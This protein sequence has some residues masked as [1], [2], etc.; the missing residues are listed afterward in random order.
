MAARDLPAF[1]PKALTFLRALVRN[2]D[3][4]WFK[5]HKEDYDRFVRDPMIAVIERLDHDFRDF[6]PELVATASQSLFRIYRDTRFSADKAPLKTHVAAVFPHRDLGKLS[7]AALYL[8]LDAKQ[9]LLAGGLHGPT[10]KDLHAVRA[11][12]AANVSRFKSIV[13]APSFRRTTG[14]LQGERAARTPRGFAV[15]DEVAEYLK[16]KQF[17]VWVEMPAALATTSGFYPTVLKIFRA[18]A[19]LVRFVNEPLVRRPVDPLR[20]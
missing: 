16:F 10:A 6:A 13:E 2:N 19:P 18:A 1:A 15:P 9:V 20:P 3:R 12:I 5:A 4:E 14:G 7:G 17:L 8:Q 11:H